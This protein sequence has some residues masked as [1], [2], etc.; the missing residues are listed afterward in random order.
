MTL[1]LRL[2]LTLVLLAAGGLLVLGG[3]TYVTQRSFQEQRIDDQTR[4]AEPALAHQL[5]EAGAVEPGARRGGPGGPDPDD[6]GRRRGPDGAGFNGGRLNGGGPDPA[7]ANLPPGTYGER[8]DGSGAR[9]G[10]PT[11]ISYGQPA[12]PA[13]VIPADIRAGKL[14]TVDAKGAGGLH[15]RLRATRTPGGAGLTLVAIPLAAV[16]AALDRLLLVMALV[17]AAVLVLLGGLAWLL[18]RAG[19]R[20]L[21]RMGQTAGAIVAGDLGRRVEDDDSRTEV[22]RLG[23]ALNGMLARLEQAFAEREASEGRLR[24]F[25]SDASHELRTPLASIRGYAELHRMG[26]L[27]EPEDAAGAMQRI[28][29]EAARMGV[30]VEDLLVLARLDE[31][32]EPVL[33]DVDVAALVQ[34][35]VADAR[36]TAPQRTITPHAGPDALVVG[37]P[38]QL[39]QVLAN[40][41]RNALVHT[42]PDS[43]IEVGAERAG[44]RVRLQVR[45][46]GPGLPPGD[47]AR[48]FDRFWRSEGAGRQ[49]GRGGAGLGLAIVAG[50]TTAHGGTVAAMD[51]PDGGASFVVALPAAPAPA[52]H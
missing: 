51:K 6:R 1:R 44:D 13:P 18:V 20:P 28:E 9:L 34:D 32:R 5:D 41:V 42:P 52:V 46:H 2:V 4:A 16:D 36:A 21:E 27:A 50:I 8:R 47:P 49:K 25:L 11:V 17:F 39:R 40:L 43:A 14:V 23:V 7:S 24:Q 3:V 35:A 33:V 15:Y 30:L 31:L 10:S 48:L 26:A 29:D 19:L 45:D 22:G 38:D 37:D 12:L